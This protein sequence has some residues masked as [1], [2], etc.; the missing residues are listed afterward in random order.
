MC[1]LVSSI[2]KVS[3]C[4]KEIWGSIL[5][6]TKNHLVSWSDDKE[7]LSGVNVIDWNSL[8]K[9]KREILRINK[10]NLSMFLLCFILKRELYLK[11]E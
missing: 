3:E 5:A 9:T 4:W 10:Q 7:L 8:K 6:Y 2:N 11:V 1:V